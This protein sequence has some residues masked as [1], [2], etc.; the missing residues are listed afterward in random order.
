M[1]D[2]QQSTKKGRIEV[3]GGIAAPLGGIIGWALANYLHV[4]NPEQLGVL[5]ASLI[6]AATQIAVGRHNILRD[7]TAE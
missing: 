1:N 3:A 5:I 7:E 4:P 2:N 6:I